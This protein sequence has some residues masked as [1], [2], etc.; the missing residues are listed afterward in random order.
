MAFAVNA[1]SMEA[2]EAR[3]VGM[4]AILAFVLNRAGR[5]FAPPPR[6]A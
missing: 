5:A 1:K 2:S 3:G 6:F 4:H